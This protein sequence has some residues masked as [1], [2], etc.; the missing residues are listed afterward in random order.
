MSMIHMTDSEE[1]LFDLKYLEEISD[2]FGECVEMD[3]Y[4]GLNLF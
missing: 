1:D 2:L 3:N 4:Y